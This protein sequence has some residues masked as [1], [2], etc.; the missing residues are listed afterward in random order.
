MDATLPAPH[1]P[2]FHGSRRCSRRQGVG[3]A[4][5]HTVQIP[6]IRVAGFVSWAASGRCRTARQTVPAAE[7]LLWSR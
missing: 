3:H 7:L 1:R 2:Y 5:L 6:A 4:R